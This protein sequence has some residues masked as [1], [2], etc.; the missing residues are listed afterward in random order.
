M[1]YVKGTSTTVPGLALLPA[2]GNSRPLFFLAAG[3]I[4]A[5]VAIFAA[6]VIMARKNRQ[7]EAN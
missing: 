6:S 2:T 3:L 5:G 1:G 7:S 4:A